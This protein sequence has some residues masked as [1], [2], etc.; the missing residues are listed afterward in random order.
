MLKIRMQRYGKKKNPVYR[1]SVI[2]K[3]Q[4]R[5]GKPVEMLGFYNPKTKEL[6]LNVERAKYWRSVGAQPSETVATLLE[7]PVAHDLSTGE[8]KYVAK[9][10]EDKQ[11]HLDELQKKNTKVTKAEK[12]N[13]EKAAEE[14]KKRKEEAEA[15]AAEEAAAKEAAAAAAAEAAAKPAEEAA[16]EEAAT[17]EA[18]AAE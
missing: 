8:F 13:K 14:E 12:K 16:T 6:I 17:E 15:K 3:A 4:R 10:R 9:S 1:I 2:E 5:N 7:R 18:P 11:K